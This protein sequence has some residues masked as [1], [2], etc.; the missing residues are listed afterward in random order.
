MSKS[1]KELSSFMDAYSFIEYSSGQSIINL[2]RTVDLMRFVYKEFYDQFKLS[3]PKFRVLLLL[4]KAEDGIPLTDIGKMLL[5]SRA[6]MTT[7]IE[8]MVRDGSVEKRSNTDDKRSIKAYL[9][10]AGEKLLEEAVDSHREFSLRLV[11]VLSEEEKNTMNCLL[12]KIQMDV[13]DGF[14]E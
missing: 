3:E 6:N 14:S 5:V 2:S 8:R 9:T 7:L 11:R 10:K 1:V 13:I 4:S 12:T